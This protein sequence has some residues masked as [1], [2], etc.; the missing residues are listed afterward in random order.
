M[1]R[2][3]SQPPGHVLDNTDCDDIDP[4]INPDI[5]WY[6]DNDGD[7]YGTSSVSKQECLQPGGYV[8]DNTDCDDFEINIYPGGPPARVIGTQTI[9]FFTLQNAFNIA[10][11]GESIEIKGG[12]YNTD[13]S[14]LNINSV[15]LTGGYDCS[16][17]AASGNTNITGD[18]TISIGTLTI[19]DGKLE[20]GT[21]Q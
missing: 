2:Q 13:I 8:L 5:Y 7:G 3:C 1:I 4:A 19:N 15:T 20:I 17:T 11:E 18:L 21:L 12:T 6:L 14:N 10:G 16:F 9:Y